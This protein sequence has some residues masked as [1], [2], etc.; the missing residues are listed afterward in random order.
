LRTP[1]T[2]DVD[3]AVFVSDEKF[4]VLGNS[5]RSGILRNDKPQ[6][7]SCQESNEAVS[8]WMNELLL[9]AARRRVDL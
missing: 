7:A 2:K 8:K 9:T 6:A 1:N 3:I 4:K 5:I